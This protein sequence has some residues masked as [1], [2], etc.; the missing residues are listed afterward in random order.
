MGWEPIW[1]D[2]AGTTPSDVCCATLRDEL[3]LNETG[4]RRLEREP[5]EEI[6]GGG[7]GPSRGGGGARIHKAQIFMVFD[8]WLKVSSI[9][10]R[11]R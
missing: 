6:R 3:R 2:V 7:A 8:A 4:P 1:W 11:R 9:D 5:S 10:G